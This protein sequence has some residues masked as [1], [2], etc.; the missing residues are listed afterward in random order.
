L[1]EKVGEIKQR[2]IDLLG[3]SVPTGTPIFC[4]RQ[5]VCHMI[6]KHGSDYASFGHLLEEI[7][8]CPNYVSLHP[9]DGS[10][11]YIKEIESVRKRVLVA[12]RIS[13]S[14]NYFARTL[15]IMSEEKWH[16]YKTK[17][18]LKVYEDPE[19]GTVELR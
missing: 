7:I 11:Q 8:L 13:V 1:A 4:G 14:V 16:H 10:I 9:S 15:F 17:G 18:Y 12:V 2:E 3:L 6:A 19:Q 5:N